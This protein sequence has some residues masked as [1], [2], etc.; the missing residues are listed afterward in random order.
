MKFTILTLF[1]KIFDSYLNESILKRAQENKKISIE[2][3]G[4]RKYT[5]DKHH[6]AD[7][8]PYGG[9]PGMLMKAE[10]IL[11]AFSSIKKSKDKPAVFIMSAA[12]KKFT[13]SDAKKYAKK[14]KNIVL[15]AGRYEGIDAR[16][17]KIL[18]AQEISVGDYVLTGGELPAMVIIDA[19]SRQIPGVLGRAESLEESRFGVG[20]P[21]YTRPET[22]KYKGEKY[23]V[24]K[25][26]L[27]GD[28][29]KIAEWRNAQRS[30]SNAK[31]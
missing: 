8:K 14:Y 29:K 7:D 3:I 4:I 2:T 13:N 15:I 27:S 22:L 20:I 28:H 16:V 25:V 30:K 21:S 11:K 26:L 9:G 31:R 19:I 18:K 10:P 1:P 17:K 5:H 12:G 23:V 6:T 24:P